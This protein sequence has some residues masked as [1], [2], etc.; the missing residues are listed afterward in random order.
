MPRL[1]PAHPD[2]WIKID[3]HTI[4]KIPN[5]TGLGLDRL[6]IGF[7]RGTSQLQCRSTLILYGLSYA[8]DRKEAMAWVG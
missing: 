8:T 5:P 4:L 6:M 2:W 1:P 7:R 3:T